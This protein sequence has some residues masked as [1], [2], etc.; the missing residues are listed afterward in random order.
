MFPAGW[1]EGAGVLS[2]V[3]RSAMKNSADRENPAYYAR[4]RA[5]NVLDKGIS[6][7]ILQD[8]LSGKT[9]EQEVLEEINKTQELEKQGVE[10]KPDPNNKFHDAAVQIAKGAGKLVGV[11]ASY[12]SNKAQ[13]LI[14]ALDNSVKVTAFEYER[15]TLVEARED[16]LEDNRYDQ[17]RDMTDDQIDEMA[18]DIIQRTQQNKDQAMPI[19][20]MLTRTPYFR[21]LAAPFAR[22]MGESPR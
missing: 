11:T 18:A 3:Q 5:L 15:D 10:E 21:V 8:L 22:F 19:V 20:N 12:G 4:L 2:N 9:T 7:S 14:L 17:F 13:G 1:E 16:S 6:Y